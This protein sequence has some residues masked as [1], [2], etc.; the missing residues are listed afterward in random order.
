MNKTKVETDKSADEEIANR[1]MNAMVIKGKTLGEL[2][3]TTG[4]KPHSIRRSLHQSR[5]DARSLTF[6]EFHRIAAA[7]DL[8]PSA[9]LPH[10]LLAVKI[11]A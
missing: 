5:A 10:E 8:P 7:L 6:R 3:E 1:I 11:P 2:S 4:I 9:L